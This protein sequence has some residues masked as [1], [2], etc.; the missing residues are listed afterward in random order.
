MKYH[1]YLL[2]ELQKLLPRQLRQTLS[3]DDD[4]AARRLLKEIYAS[5]KGGLARAAQSDDAEY[6]AVVYRQVYSVQR[7]DLLV[8]CVVDLAEIF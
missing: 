1:T 7:D 4:L 5:H 2:A 3:V 8:C 6:L